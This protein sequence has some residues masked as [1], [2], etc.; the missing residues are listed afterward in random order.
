MR[1][2]V[3]GGRG[4]LNEEVVD[5]ELSRLV[6]QAQKLGKKI[7]FINGGAPGLDRLVET[8]CLRQGV[9]CIT[10]FAPWD[11][12]LKK[13]AGPVRNQWM[14]DYGLPTYG[15]VFPG[16]KG[17]ADMHQRLNNCKINHHVV[18]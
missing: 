12:H 5:R 18:A 1:V 15:V 2:V 17:T 7:V 13:S 6:V 10:M 8:W 14:I 9:P 4:F 16:G 3:T 11:S